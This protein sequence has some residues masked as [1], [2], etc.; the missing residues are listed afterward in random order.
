M[1]ICGEIENL[2]AEVKFYQDKIREVKY[3]IHKLKMLEDS[4]EVEV[5]PKDIW[6]DGDGGELYE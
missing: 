6:H 3:K 5:S 4:N 2:E 1:S